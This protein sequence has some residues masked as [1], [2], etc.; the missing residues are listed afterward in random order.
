M[1]PPRDHFPGGFFHVGTRANN[2]SGVL[3]D[4]LL[5]IGTRGG[6]LAAMPGSGRVKL[7]PDSAR[8]FLGDDA[9]GVLLNRHSTRRSFPLPECAVQR[10]A[11]PMECLF[12]LPSPPERE[13]TP[14]I[15]IRPLSRVATC[16]ELLKNSFNIEILDNDRLAR[17]LTFAADIA[18]RIDACQLRY[19]RGLHHLDAVRESVVEHVQRRIGRLSHESD[20][21]GDSAEAA[22]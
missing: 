12:V 22:I 21:P 19:P 17:Q 8:A 16:R 11:L 2:R 1:R 9:R 4:D 10:Q 7:E 3:T 18:S 6:R 13:D 20:R 5:M 15:E 14:A